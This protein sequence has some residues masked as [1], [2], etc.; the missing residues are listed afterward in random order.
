MTS[1]PSVL[2]VC[3]H[4]AGK[5]QMAAGLMTDLAGDAVDV[6]S[7]GTAP[8]TKVNGEAAESLAE[9]GIDISTQ[10]PKAVPEERVRAVDVVVIPGSGS[11]GPA[12]RG[13]P[14]RAVGHRRALRAGHRGHG[15]DAVDSRRHRRPRPDAGVGA[16][17]A[18]CCR[19]RCRAGRSVSLGADRPQRACLSVLA[20]STMALRTS[21]GEPGGWP[22]VFAQS[23]RS[24]V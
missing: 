9:L 19:A 1:T 22:A 20:T 15:A 2:F 8:G 24:I 6:H 3:V 21:C 13:H 7:A 16:G 17:G 10:Q 5:S 23:R 18:A 4:N 14:G 11:P 12:G